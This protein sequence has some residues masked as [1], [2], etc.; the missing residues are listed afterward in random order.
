MTPSEK[1]LQK[2]LVTSGLDSAHWN[3]VQA[4]MRDRGFFSSHVESAKFIYAARAGV[5]DIV[6]A[7]KSSSEIRRDLRKLLDG[8][9]YAAAHGSEGGVQDL[10]SQARLD[11]II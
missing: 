8:E 5:S 10:R 7:N 4:G 3:Q 2:T 1:I 9:G 6:A 11:L